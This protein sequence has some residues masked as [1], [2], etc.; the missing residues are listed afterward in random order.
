[1]KLPH[2]EL[3]HVAVH[4]TPAAALSWVTTALIVA[5]LS[6]TRVTGGAVPKATE[7]GAGAGLEPDPPPQA[8]RLRATDRA[9]GAEYLR[10]LSTTQHSHLN[11][12]GSD[13]RRSH[14]ARILLMSRAD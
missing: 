9:A 14:E 3:E 1:M 6:A 5:L 4:F 2:R 12:K 11:A 10:N 7:I 13:M 8:L